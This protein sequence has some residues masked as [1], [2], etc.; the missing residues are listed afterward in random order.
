MADDETSEDLRARA[1]AANARAHAAFGRWLWALTAPDAG[2][3]TAELAAA[4]RAYARAQAAA[5]R[6]HRAALGL[7]PAAYRAHL[8]ATRVRAT[9]A[10]AELAR[11]WGVTPAAARG[12]IDA[13][14]ARLAAAG[15]VVPGLLANLDGGR[16]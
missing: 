14:Q 10:V 15:A 11:L 8:G 6:L 16:S 4:E 12:R 13:L 7:D 2:D 3:R 1:T 9:D 5:K